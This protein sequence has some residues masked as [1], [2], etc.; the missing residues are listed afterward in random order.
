MI[1]ELRVMQLADLEAAHASLQAESAQVTGEQACRC[2]NLE[3]ALERE[4]QRVHALERRSAWRLCVKAQY[5]GLA[6]A[7]RRH[8]AC[9]A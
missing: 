8:A 5:W 1:V 3:M 2:S 4:R 6:L 9:P 7:L